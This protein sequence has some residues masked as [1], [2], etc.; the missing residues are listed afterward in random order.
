ML[1][2]REHHHVKGVRKSAKLNPE[3]GDVLCVYE[4]K[5]PRNLWK[6]GKV[7]LLFK[8]K[9]GHVRAVALRVCNTGKETRTLQRLVQ[10][11]YPA[12]VSR[13]RVVNSNDVPVVRRSKQVAAIVIEARKKY[14]K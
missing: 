5:T 1:E 14:E 12:E 3:E 2:L 8:G 9:D 13:S 11:I 4:E 6:L 7:V 10:K